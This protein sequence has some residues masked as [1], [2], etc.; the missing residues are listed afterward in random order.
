[1]NKLQSLHSHTTNS[2]G[3]YNHLELLE[4]SKKY[5][6]NTIAFTDHDSVISKKQIES[7]KE[8]EG[9]RWISGV[10]ISSGWPLDLGGG[11]SSS[12]HIVGLFVDYENQKLKE[13]C[14][15]AQEARIERMA[16]MTKNLNGIGFKVTQD[17]CIKQSGAEAVARPH[18]VKALLSYQENL[19]RIEE[20]REDMRKA[21]EKDSSLLLSYNRLPELPIEQYPYILF[22]TE[23]S[24]I[25]NIYVDYLY[26][27]DFDKSVKLIRDSG[28]V[29]IL[30]HYFTCSNK[31]TPEILDKYVK[32]KRVDGLETVFGLYAFGTS[33]EQ[34]IVDSMNVTKKI[35]NKYNCISSG[36]ADIH[37]EK[38]F[39]MLSENT[40]YAN[41]T[42]NLL[43]NMLTNFNLN[44]THS[45]I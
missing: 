24:F 20:I 28:G 5:N 18:I 41:Q 25:K 9:I 35:A 7:I 31:I 42:K 12:L 43:E 30:A 13:Y 2:D 10:E 21:S 11:S 22:L 39:K 45:N 6:I 3:Q 36:G 4:I 40:E 23:D 44:T 37:T 33:E 38:D 19:K 32:E 17:D 8:V 1:M 15:L 27:L 26:Y 29:A 34:R 14:K 16:R